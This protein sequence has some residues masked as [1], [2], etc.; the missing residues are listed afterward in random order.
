MGKFLWDVREPIYRFMKRGGH[1]AE[2]DEQKW[3]IAT[4]IHHKPGDGVTE[5]LSA[6]LEPRGFDVKLYPHNHKIGREILD[7]HYGRADKKMRIAQRLSGI[8]PDKFEGTI[9]LMC[10]ATRHRNSL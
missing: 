3:A 2:N 7:G 8:H 1:R 9:I 6:T 5:G 10:V 4:E